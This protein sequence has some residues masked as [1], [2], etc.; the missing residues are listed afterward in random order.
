M[1]PAGGNE[2]KSLEKL[3]KHGTL[4]FNSQ[5]NEPSDSAVP[6]V[7]NEKQSDRYLRD[8]WSVVEFTIHQRQ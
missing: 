1:A 5:V 2:A 4:K 7:Y 6:L 8:R 3:S